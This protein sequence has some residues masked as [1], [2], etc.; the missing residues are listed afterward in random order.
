[1][2]LDIAMDEDGKAKITPKQAAPCKIRVSYGE[3]TRMDLSPYIAKGFPGNLDELIAKVPVAGIDR[4]QAHSMV[5]VCKATERHLYEGSYSPTSVRY[6]TGARPQLERITASLPAGSPRERALA[7]MAWVC[8]HVAHPHIVGPIP[9]DRAMTEEQIIA[10]GVGWCNEQARVFIALCETMGIPAR[11]CFLFHKNGRTGHAAAEA[12]VDGRWAFFDVTFDLT[13]TLPSVLLAEA[14]ELSGRYR[15]LAH[16]AYAPAL[17]DYYARMHPSNED[18]P[19]WNKAD[20]PDPV[21]G[22]DLLH[23][24]GIA[25]Y[26][27]EGIVE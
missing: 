10:S 3:Q 16:R 4:K 2:V 19:G 27:I 17:E 23:T 12:Y 7:T 1:V 18:A 22:G 20:R 13:V 26:L 21:E 6:R 11:V 8:G 14:R 24:L 15:K 25:N 9:P 5:R